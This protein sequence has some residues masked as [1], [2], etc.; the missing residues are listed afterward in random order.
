MVREL[1][2]GK[3]E[4]ETEP[5]SDQGARIVVMWS[6]RGGGRGGGAAQGEGIRSSFPKWSTL[7]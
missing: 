7:A 3:L 1:F 2:K 5:P 6:R 4:T